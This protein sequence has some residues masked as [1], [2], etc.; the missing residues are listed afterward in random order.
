MMSHYKAAAMAGNKVARYNL[1]VMEFKSGKGEQATKQLTI[2]ASPGHYSAMHNLL[3]DLREGLVS[4]ESIDSTLTAYNNSCV[5]M[6]SE[7]RDA[8]IHVFMVSNLYTA[9]VINSSQHCF[10][11]A[12]F[13]TG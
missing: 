4:R 7:A 6:R 10:F 3:I 11:T 8:A 1:G 12:S 5:K 9:Q 13:H 2:A